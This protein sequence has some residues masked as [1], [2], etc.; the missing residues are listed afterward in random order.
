[1]S[2]PK[3]KVGDEVYVVWHSGD[4]GRWSVGKVEIARVLTMPGLK[5]HYVI[6]DIA[7]REYSESVVFDN[8]DDAI[9]KMEEYQ[10]DE[11]DILQR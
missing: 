10:R 3:Y 7:D 2:E 11:Q 1:M 8:A 5:P 9:A 6:D 4:I